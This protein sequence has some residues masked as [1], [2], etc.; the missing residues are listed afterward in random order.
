MKK[1]L[2]D[3][4]STKAPRKPR[5]REIKDDVRFNTAL[6][7]GLQILAIF[8][9]GD[10]D[11]DAN[12]IKDRTGIPAQTL[13]KLTLTLCELGYMLLDEST[14]RFRLAPS[15]LDLGYGVLSNIDIDVIARPLMM[16]LADECGGV[17]SLAV[18]DGDSMI[19][20]E[21]ARGAG[22][23]LRNI[24]V[25]MKVP[26]ASTSLGWACLASMPQAAR[27]EVLK[28]IRSKRPP[29]WSSI[30]ENIA[31]GISEVSARGY[32][33][34]IGN[35]VTQSN[36]VGVPLPGGSGDRYLAFNCAGPADTFTAKQ[37]TEKWGPRLLALA[38]A[39]GGR[40][41]V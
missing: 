32:C 16:E 14:E 19:Y 10:V 3:V 7:R 2:A 11:L 6:A 23:M 1:R 39:V 38:R 18:L 8:R 29:D 27:E 41:T 22:P 26:V 28:E 34:N 24:S 12:E 37:L 31:R 35:Y 9:E 4:Q 36:A 17:V 20:I 40:S 5:V 33:C 13:Q 15:V 25:G 30:Q 21:T